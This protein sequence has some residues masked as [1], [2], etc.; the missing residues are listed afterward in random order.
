M[1]RMSFYFGAAMLAAL[2]PQAALGEDVAVANM[3]GI[4]NVTKKT[5]VTS[6]RPNLYY[7]QLQITTSQF[8]VPQ[9]AKGKKR[10]GK[11]L[12]QS[13]GLKKETRSIIV[14]VAVSTNLATYPENPVLIYKFDGDSGLTSV[15]RVGTVTLPLQ[16]LDPAEPIRVR[17]T[18]RNSRDVT[19]DVR[20]AA[21]AISSIV[22]GNTLVSVVT[23]PFVAKVSDLA[24]AVFS[25]AASQTVASSLAEEM[26]PYGTFAKSMVVELDK[27]DGGAFG[28]IT[29]NLL[30]T[31]TLQ[32]PPEPV[33][34][35][36]ATDDF[37]LEPG[38]GATTLSLNIGGVER[39]LVTELK[40]LDSFVRL[41]KER[42]PQ[43]A[44]AFCDASRNLLA[45]SFKL[46]IMDRALVMHQAMFDADAALTR[47]AWYDSCFDALEVTSLTQ[48]SED[49]ARPAVP[50]V[51]VDPAG[52]VPVTLKDAIG[53]WMTGKG[54]TYCGSRAPNARESLLAAMADRV[55]IG[56]IDYAGL[57]DI[58]TLDPATRLM[59]KATLV[60]LLASKAS[61]FSCYDRGLFL[62]VDNDTRAF[63]FDASIADGKITGINLVVIP[64]DA[65]QCT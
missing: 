18:Y 37:A 26:S 21:T 56:Q 48:A 35:A 44:K 9:D 51:R 58:S 12:L 38:E 16:R 47:G 62:G 39:N 59:P 55:R 54:G 43:A 33:S 36:T 53:C 50:P 5:D 8:D 41:S 63:R 24:G 23:Q 49:L 34:S 46:T 40:G 14:S 31:P 19:V 17:F 22:P 2:L 7:T 42:T 30:A 4:K 52:P 57:I 64:P 25:L 15:D 20:S 29:L 6:V 10:L 13:L 3:P 32:R 27:P 61:S 1:K 11:A 45:T 28:E 60:D 65:L